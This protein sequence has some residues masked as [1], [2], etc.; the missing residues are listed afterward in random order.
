VEQPGLAPKRLIQKLKLDAALEAPVTK[1]ASRPGKGGFRQTDPDPF[2]RKPI[3]WLPW[4]AVALSGT[5]ALSHELLWTRRLVDLLGAT[6]E[7]SARVIACFFLGLSMGAAITPAILR[8]TER[9][10]RLAAFVEIGIALLCLPLFFLPEMVTSFWE[11]LGPDQLGTARAQAMKL[12]VSAMFIVPPALLMGTTLPLMVAG[13]LQSGRRLRRD[14]IWQYALN[15]AGGVA[16]ILLSTHLTMWL[17]GVRGAMLVAMGLNLA[18]AGVCFALDTL[19]SGAMATSEL[20][21]ETAGRAVKH[22][23]GQVEEDERGAKGNSG[24]ESTE[25]KILGPPMTLAFFSGFGVLSFEVLC[26]HLFS[27]VVSN[28]NAITTVL[29]AFIFVL[30]LAAAAVPMF[31]PK[32]LPADRAI[33]MAL[34]VASLFIALT[35]VLFMVL[36]DDM[37]TLYENASSVFAFVAWV[38][39]TVIVA[40]GIAIFCAGLVFPMTIVAVD[41]EARSA[42]SRWGLL[43]AVNGLGGAIGAEFANN[44]V[45]SSVGLNVGFGVVAVAYALAAFGV[46]VFAIKQPPIA[47]TGLSAVALMVC[48][49]LT[50]LSLPSLPVV[51]NQETAQIVATI[52]GPDGVVAVVQRT[53]QLPIGPRRSRSMV[54][55]S[56]YTLGGTVAAPGERR[57][58]ILPLMLHPAPAKVACLGLATGITAGATLDV[59]G[60]LELTVVELSHQVVDAAQ[61]YFGMHNR[62]ICKDPRAEIV[63]EDARTFMAACENR[64][65]VILG[66]FFRPHATGE[67]RLFTIEHFASTKNALREG[68]HYCQWIPCYQID[69]REFEVILASFLT[70]FGEA[71]IWRLNHKTQYTGIGLVGYKRG[72][73]DFAGLD[74][75]CERLREAGTVLDPPSRHAESIAMH[76][77]GRLDTSDIRTEQR[78]TLDNLW[79]ELYGGRRDATHDAFKSSL[80]NAHFMEFERNLYQRTAEKRQAAGKLARWSEVGLL[81]SRWYYAE[82]KRD[83]DRAALLAEVQAALPVALAEDE[84]ADW[85]Y[86]PAY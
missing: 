25:W 56:Q 49:A 71:D 46:A 36:T 60:V 15:T 3:S 53:L 54:L 83:P 66:D 80:V 78:N 4:L 13:L 21:N 38:T 76:Y 8:R 73:P 24:G 9:A 31:V 47:I 74:R 48:L 10:W 33:V 59:P 17:F 27:H 37:S 62:A 52:P 29:A 55:N 79:L 50:F 81:L 68:G 43:L 65:D 1:K 64:F 63:V 69:E 34:A 2:M 39:T 28:L 77:V 86:W 75:R 57:Q 19:R 84:G 18:T 12:I 7:A 40:A 51:G 85:S 72:G 22:A 45:M 67:G 35:P 23:T 26:I 58:A 70:V 44:V 6:H 41:D 16:G 14:G 5:A 42:N 61:M 82:S 32:R 30:F 11:Q 20:G